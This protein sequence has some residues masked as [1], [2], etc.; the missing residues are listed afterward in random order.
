LVKV[1]NKI[2]W[3]LLIVLLGYGYAQAIP[4]RDIQYTTDPSGN[5]PLNGQTVTISGVV[6]GVIQV[7]NYANKLYYIQDGYGAWNGIYCYDRNNT[8]TMGDSVAVTGVVLEYSGLTEIS[9][10]TAFLLLKSNCALPLPVVLPTDSL[11]TGSPAAE[12]YES[13][14]ISTGKVR[15]TAT[16]NTY[17]EWRIASSATSCLVNDGI[18]SISHIGYTPVLNDSLVSVT[19]ILNYNYSDFKIEPRTSKDV[20]TFKPPYIMYAF[21][22][23]NDQRVPTSITPN[24]YFS[25]SMDAS[26]ITADKFVLTRGNGSAVPLSMYYDNVNQNCILNPNT[27]FACGESLNLWISHDIHDTLGQSLDGNRD[28]LAID[29]TSEDVN[30]RFVIIPSITTL[31]DVQKP[32]TSGFN[33]QYNGQ[34]VT[35]E[36]VISSPTSA[37]AAYIQD[38]NGGANI[39]YSSANFYLGQ[40]VVITG[41]VLEYSGITEITSLSSITNW[42]Y[43]YALPVAK[44]L[45]YNQFPTEVIEGI[46]VQFD[47]TISSPPSYAGGGYN[48]EIRNG[49][50]AIAIRMYEVGGFRANVVNNYKLGTK[51]RVTGVVSQYDK[52]A[53]FNSG[54]QIVPRYPEAYTY[55]GIQY[56][57]D[58]ELLADSVLPSNSVQ[59]TN[60]LP[61]PFSPDYGEL[62]NI[63]V[64]A[65]AT[66]H[67][68]LRI[69][70]L[71]GRLVKTLLNNVMGGHQIV[72]WEGNDQM[73]RRVNIGI[74]IVHLRCVAADGKTTDQTKLLV[75]GTKL[76]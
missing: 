51:V 66:D 22:K 7:G 11:A 64:N 52:Y 65:P 47:G 30:M 41:T 39:Y 17:N 3:L 50:S 68:T 56:P 16:Q 46:L 71:K 23:N 15:V 60:I 28:G 35:V 4:I 8:V 18:D 44:T 59:I 33:S 73:N 62:A 36:G 34:T 63:E 25:R 27:S 74:Y 26:T 55:N 49:N 9:P 67:L 13:V 5:S 19:G 2:L 10:V 58:I 48:M 12:S 29:S 1:R 43:A 20:V 61:N 21:P 69:Y 45:L 42:G 31:A 38:S 14:L 53:P 54:Y 72:P 40:R 32:D 24:I 76:K 37:G 70:D 6:T 75:M 57:A